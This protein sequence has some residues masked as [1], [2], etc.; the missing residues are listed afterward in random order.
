MDKNTIDYL[1]PTAEINAQ[2]QQ[3]YQQLQAENAKLQQQ[4]QLQQLQHENQ[5][6]KTQLAQPTPTINTTFQHSSLRGIPAIKFGPFYGNSSGVGSPYVR[7]FKQLEL[8]LTQVDPATSHLSIILE[9]SHSFAGLAAQWFTNIPNSTLQLLTVEEF[10]DRFRSQFGTASQQAAQNQLK[11]LRTP[12]LHKV[13]EFIEEFKIR[14][15]DTGYNDPALLS[16]FLD[17]LPP[18]YRQ[19]FVDHPLRET[20]LFCSQQQATNFRFIHFFI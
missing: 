17:K 14:S 11:G 2:L 3:Q 16:L 20:R 18:E 9:I 13:L 12:A 8:W 15:Q 4:I 10:L 6:L 1:S 7:Y 19:A 5:L